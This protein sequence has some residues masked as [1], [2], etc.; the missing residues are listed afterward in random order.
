[1][2]V[3]DENL[4]PQ[5]LVESLSEQLKSIQDVRN[6]TWRAWSIAPMTTFVYNNHKVLSK[7][8]ARF[9]DSSSTSLVSLPSQT[10]VRFIQLQT[11]GADN[12][13]VRREQLMALIVASRDG[14]G[15]PVSANTM[16][17]LGARACAQFFENRQKKKK[18]P[19]PPPLPPP[20]P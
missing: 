18:K 20:R 8:L 12:E 6:V 7:A 1:M 19:P 9:I 16:A 15:K 13:G 3:I 11:G 10:H 5:E 2:N 17:V 4:T 14:R